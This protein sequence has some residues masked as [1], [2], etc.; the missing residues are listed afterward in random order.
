MGLMFSSFNKLKWNAPLTAFVFI[1]SLLHPS[2]QRK[3]SSTWLGDCTHKLH[4]LSYFHFFSACLQSGKCFFAYRIVFWATFLVDCITLHNLVFNS[5]SCCSSELDKPLGSCG[6]LL[7]PFAAG[8]SVCCG[9]VTP[10]SFNFYSLR[11]GKSTFRGY[12]ALEGW[13]WDVWIGKGLEG[14]A[15]SGK[16][17]ISPQQVRK[18]TKQLGNEVA[19]K[20][21]VELGFLSFVG[22]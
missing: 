14:A 19:T 15:P 9:I 12:I 11:E 8:T 7:S 5:R 16:N 2:S 20:S 4:M 6:K 13:D 3:E 17:K 1:P 21:F 18:K 22:E 10:L